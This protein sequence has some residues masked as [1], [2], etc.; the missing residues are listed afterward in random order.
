MFSY[1]LG[2]T[3]GAELLVK[4]LTVLNLYI[5]KWVLGILYFC[6]HSSIVQSLHLL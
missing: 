4:S 3:D 6:V 1:I 2:K 5:L